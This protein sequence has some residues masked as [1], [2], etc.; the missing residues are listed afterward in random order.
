MSDECECPCHDNP[1]MKHVV[2]CCSRCDQCK[3]RIK[4]EKYEQHIQDCGTIK[5]GKK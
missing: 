4:R 1:N 5:K 3:K 2:M